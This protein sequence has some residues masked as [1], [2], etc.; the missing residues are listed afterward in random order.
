MSEHG[1]DQKETGGR[2]KILI[3]CQGSR[4][5]AR[6]KWT[7][8]CLSRAFVGG[9][10]KFLPLCG[11]TIPKHYKEQPESRRGKSGITQIEQGN[12]LQNGHC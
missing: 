4:P 10:P 7:L 12:R 5:E 1:G 2:D 3:R 6:A 8:N 9:T 11:E